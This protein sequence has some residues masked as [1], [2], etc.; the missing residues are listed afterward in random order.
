MKKLVYSISLLAAVAA[1]TFT[2]CKDGGSGG[3]VTPETPTPSISFVAG[4][5]LTSIDAKVINSDVVSVKVLITSTVDL[6]DA[7]I[8]QSVNGGASTIVVD[9]D[10]TFPN[11]IRTATYTV[12]LKQSPNKSDVIT[13]TFKATD[14]N[15]TTG[16]KSIKIT[17]IGA[18][19]EFSNDH[20][21]YNKQAPVGFNSAFDI[22]SE[23]DLSA[24]DASN[25]L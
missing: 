18:L 15:A 9:S 7:N 10:T 3:T 11:N 21:V 4:A 2:G 12:V 20:I 19:V 14:K 13:F 23:D 22:T 6:K 24:A 25:K 1:L 17:T 5:N 16:T 8:T